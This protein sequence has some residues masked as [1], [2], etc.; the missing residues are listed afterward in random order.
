MT[1]IVWVALGL[2]LGVVTGKAQMSTDF[3]ILFTDQEQQNIQTA[4]QTPPTPQPDKLHL[5]GIMFAD[6][7]NWV[8]WINDQRIT[9]GEVHPYITVHEVSNSQ[10]NCTWHR[11]GQDLKVALK[12]G[13]MIHAKH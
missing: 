13:Q 8:I 3:S 10:V 5:G 1:L 9:P 2:V 6:N 12:L 4:L 7:K 11:Q